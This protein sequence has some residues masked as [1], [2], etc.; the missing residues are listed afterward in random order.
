MTG[1]GNDDGK[2]VVGCVQVNVCNDVEDKV[3]D[4]VLCLSV[5]CW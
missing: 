4:V 3:G 5:V 2:N 1:S